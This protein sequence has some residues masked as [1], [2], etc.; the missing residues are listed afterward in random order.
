MLLPSADSSS[1]VHWVWI[2]AFLPSFLCVSENTNDFGT[3]AAVALSDAN[4][5]PLLTEFYREPCWIS[6]WCESDQARLSPVTNAWQWSSN[7][8]STYQNWLPWFEQENQ[9]SVSSCRQKTNSWFLAY[10]FLQSKAVDVRRDQSGKPA[11]D[12]GNLSR[13]RSPI[14]REIVFHSC[15]IQTMK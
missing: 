12:T 10:G 14:R 2:L 8:V 5:L 7:T 1:R 11:S 13:R 6:A 9:L 3:G 4:V 15:T